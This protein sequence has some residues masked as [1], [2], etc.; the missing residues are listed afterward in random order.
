MVTDKQQAV[1]C[2]Q[3]WGI[4][5]DKAWLLINLDVLKRI[6]VT[7]YGGL[8]MNVVAMFEELYV[9]NSGYLK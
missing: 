4:I 5:L 3:S 7:V 1:T 6:N 8:L 2:N 9:Y